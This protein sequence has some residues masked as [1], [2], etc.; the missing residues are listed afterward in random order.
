[1]SLPTSF[2]EVEF[3]G[4]PE[5]GRRISV[6]VLR[7]LKEGDESGDCSVIAVV[8]SLEEYEQPGDLTEVM[9]IGHYV[10]KHIEAGTLQYVWVGVE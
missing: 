10:A 9:L 1:M 6:E 8:K 2:S 5:D 7:Q 4:G 3:L